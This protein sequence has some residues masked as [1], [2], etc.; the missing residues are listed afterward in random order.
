[1]AA[2]LRDTRQRRAIR[3]A[4]AG[5]SGPLTSNQIY[6]IARHGLP[7][8][9]NVT[10]YRVLHAMESEGLI[11]VVVVP[12]ESP[13]YELS[14]EHHHHFFC[15]ICRRIFDIPCDGHKR[16]RISAPLFKVEEHQVVL[17]GRCV[18]CAQAA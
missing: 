6:L 16:T 3:A 4:L 13:H 14:R 2:L 9:S 7:K 8:L 17:L 1:M 12:G 11:A 15:R 5:A 18:D 10:V